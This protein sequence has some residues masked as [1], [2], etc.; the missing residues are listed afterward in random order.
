MA[1]YISTIGDDTNKGTVGIQIGM[2][3]NDHNY[4]TWN[5]TGEGITFSD[6]K[7]H[8][9]ETSDLLRADSIRILRTKIRL[10]LI[11]ISER[12][13]ICSKNSPQR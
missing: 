11:L 2:G 13:P 7:D 4:G 3:S 5:E 6:G 9:E 10:I 12:I 1:Y 8:M